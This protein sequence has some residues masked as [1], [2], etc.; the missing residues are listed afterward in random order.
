[1]SYSRNDLAL[2]GDSKGI[3]VSIDKD[4]TTKQM[5]FKTPQPDSSYA[6]QITPQWDT[7]AWVSDKTAD[8]FVIHFTPAPESARLDWIITR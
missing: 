5:T 7:K 8:G 4:A 3:N 6:V 1:L 2:G